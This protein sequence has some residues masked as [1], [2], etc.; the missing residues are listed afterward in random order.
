[1]KRN[2]YKIIEQ[3][4]GKNTKR[5]FKVNVC[6]KKKCKSVCVARHTHYNET[7][8]EGQTVVKGYFCCFQCFMF[9]T[10]TRA[11]ERAHKT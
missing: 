1:M 5:A 11:G 9:N 4:P 10:T 3:S 2:A 8:V 7:K 6:V